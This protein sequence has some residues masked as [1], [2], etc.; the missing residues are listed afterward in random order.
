MCIVLIAINQIPGLPVVI[1]HNRDEFG[2][3]P[4]QGAHYWSHRPEI[5]GGLD[6][7]D[8]GT[9][10]GITKQGR[11]ATITNYRDPSR[12]DATKKSRGTILNEFLQSDESVGGF[13]R[14]L[15]PRRD[16]YNLFNLIL[17][18]NM[19]EFYWYSGL[20]DS[21]AV[22]PHGVHALSNA[23]FD[24]P[25]PKVVRLKSL[26]I[27]HL[28]TGTVGLNERTTDALLQILGD[29]TPAEPGELPK[30]GLTF[31]QELGVSP[32]CVASD[33]YGTLVS[34]VILVDEQGRTMFREVIFR[35]NHEKLSDHVFLNDKAEA[36]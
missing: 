35:P 26:V 12:F 3:R 2:N 16:H 11:F 4:F 9:W 32:I 36:R 30:T 1:A 34:T 13:I 19:R 8:G 24:T 29:R 17:S 22:I 10:L 20:N 27:E 23:D 15:S 21:L 31:E 28:N 6:Q 7:R 25:W 5:L 14:G 33:F 18:D